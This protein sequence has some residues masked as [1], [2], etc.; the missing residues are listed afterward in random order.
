MGIIKKEG[1]VL[2]KAGGTPVEE[3]AEVKDFRGYPA[4]IVGGT[5]PHKVSST[6]RVQTKAGA[7]FFPGMF[8]LKWVKEE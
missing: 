1:W 5:P 2:C 4:V 6:G 3:G 7:E 8:N